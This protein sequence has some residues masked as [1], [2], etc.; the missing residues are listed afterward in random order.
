MLRAAARDYLADRFPLD[1]VVGLIDDEP[2]WD[3]ASWAELARLGWL[4]PELGLVEQAVL[5]EEAGYAL[6]PGPWWSTVALCAGLV[7]TDR[8][9]TL[10][11]AEDGAPSLAASDRFTTKADGGRLSGRKLHV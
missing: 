11:W 2:G 9:A 6:Y 1:R 10:A 8:P 3:P 5:A 4:D 7:P